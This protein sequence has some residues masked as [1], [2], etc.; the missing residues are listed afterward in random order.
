MDQTYLHVGRKAPV[1]RY[2][3]RRQRREILVVN[4]KGQPTFVT[5]PMDVDG[6]EYTR[7]FM[8]QV[9]PPRRA[10]SLRLSP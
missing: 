10:V 1:G 6:P 4:E 9:L 7:G 8:N 3:R 2:R 5:D